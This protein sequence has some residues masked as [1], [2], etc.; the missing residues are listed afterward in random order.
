VNEQ[1]A[2]LPRYLTAHLELT[3]FSLLIG[4]SLS[5]PLGVLSARSPRLERPVLLAASLVQTVPSLALLALMVPLLAALGLPSIGKVPAFVALVLYSVLPVLRNTVTGLTGID[6]ALVEAARAVGMTRREQLLRVDLPLALPV[7]VAGIRT[8]ASWTVGMATLSTPVGGVSLGN[9]IFSGLQ[10]RNFTAVLV[11]CVAAALLAL[12][13]DALA[14]LALVGLERRRRAPL[15]ASLAGFSALSLFALVSLV[16]GA[17]RSGPA[18]VVIGA[19][20]FTEQYI[21]AQVMAQTIAQ[22]ANAPTSIKES[23]GSTVAFDALANGD[24]DAYVDYSGTLWATILHKSGSAD[25]ARVL[26]E[27]RE[28]LAQNYGIRL[29]GALGFENAYALA[30]RR[31]RARELGLTSIAD[32]APHA[33]RL[34]IGGDYEFFQRPEWKALVERYGLSFR[35]Q[36]SM[37]PSLMV[38]AVARGTVD[39]ISAFSS[40]GR[41]LADDLVLL[42]DDRGA[43]PPYDAVLL[44]GKR[45]ASER[46]E[47]LQA[48]GSLTGRIDPDSMR[49]MNLEV[50]SKH[51]SPRDVARKFVEGRRF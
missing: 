14:R 33:A 21:L 48:L 43:I 19:K 1:L 27:T 15:I 49:A 51:V 32:L 31:S 6:P 40:D 44:V 11:G 42:R 24:I 50:D 18:P 8:A 17:V 46:P 3:L 25:R 20:T 41:I 26:A 16:A 10:T 29:V 45:L 36:R 38:D 12:S 13:L 35:E 37:D 22:K 5:V 4:V 30:V 7:I 39:V 34:S 2:L 9:Y 28:F 23:L 47:V